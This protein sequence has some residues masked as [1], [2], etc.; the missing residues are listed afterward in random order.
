MDGGDLLLQEI[1][2]KGG[3]T[4][5]WEYDLIVKSGDDVKRIKLPEGIETTSFKR[6][7]KKYALKEWCLCLWITQ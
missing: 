3:H 7:F 6:V 2:S 1:I 5:D 4:H